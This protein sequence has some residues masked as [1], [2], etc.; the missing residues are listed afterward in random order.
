MFFTIQR[1]ATPREWTLLVTVVL[2]DVGDWNSGRYLRR[3]GCSA[4]ADATAPPGV[5]S[6][7]PTTSLSSDTSLLHD[8]DSECS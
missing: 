7:S 6:A 8:G 5:R 2:R 4:A 1:G 3:T